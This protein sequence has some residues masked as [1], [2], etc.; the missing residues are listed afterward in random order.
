MAAATIPK[1]GTTAG[2]CA[3]ACEH[4]DCQHQRRDAARICH[5]CS[6]PI[7]YGRGL[8][9]D[10]ARDERLVHADCEEAALERTVQHREAVRGNL[11]WIAQG[12]VNVDTDG[13]ANV[14]RDSAIHRAMAW[15]CTAFAT[16]EGRR[17]LERELD[18]ME[19]DHYREADGVARRDDVVH[20]RLETGRTACNAETK[21]G[22]TVQLQT[23]EVG[24]LTTCPACRSLLERFR[25]TT[26]PEPVLA[27]G[28]RG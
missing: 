18:A 28:A 15:I 17:A 8:Y 11:A 12:V 20:H 22:P 24:Q 1:P 16:P 9:T 27:P 13:A 2:P 5:W 7:G 21:L 26:V 14:E 25:A 19:A 10:P 6:E 23:T 3:D 4:R